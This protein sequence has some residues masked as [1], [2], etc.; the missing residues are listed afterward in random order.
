[1]SIGP[2]QSVYEKWWRKAEVK[3]VHD[4]DTITVWLD[5]GFDVWTLK[6]LRLYGLNCPELRTPDGKIAWEFTVN[7]L[8][9]EHAGHGGFMAQY[10][11]WDKFAPRFDGVLICGAAH[12]LNDDLL[13]AGMAK[14]YL[15]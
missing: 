2:G 1:M 9:T 6:P 12:C 8:Y 5:L 15:P 4:G 14:P 11:S 3:S 10:R 13:A 7:W